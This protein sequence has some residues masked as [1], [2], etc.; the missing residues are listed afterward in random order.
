MRKSS[1]IWTIHA[2]VMEESAFNTNFGVFEADGTDM[3]VERLP[4]DSQNIGSQIIVQFDELLVPTNSRVLAAN[5]QF[6][7]R[8]TS[9]H[10]QSHSLSA[11]FGTLSHKKKKNYCGGRLE[12]SSAR[13]HA[14]GSFSYI[15]E[16]HNTI[17]QNTKHGFR[18]VQLSTSHFVPLKNF[19]RSCTR[20]HANISHQKKIKFSTF[21]I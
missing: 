13:E 4:F 21:A 10:I 15:F 8:I 18:L 9:T 14:Q 11:I 7:V 20:H 5:T 17:K 6:T 3:D 19:S 2:D 1:N 16:F 12:G